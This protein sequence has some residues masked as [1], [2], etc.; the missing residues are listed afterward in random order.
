IKITEIVVPAVEGKSKM[1]PISEILK[2]KGDAEKG[3]ITA[4]RCIMCH[5]VG[6]LSQFP[7]HL[8]ER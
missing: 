8:S 1:P 5:R 4:A 6:G 3:K 2:L 7:R